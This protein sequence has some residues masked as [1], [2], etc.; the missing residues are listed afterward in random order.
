MERTCDG[1]CRPLYICD[2]KTIAYVCKGLWSVF[3]TGQAVL[4]ESF[5]KGE[6]LGLN[7]KF[8]VSQNGKSLAMLLEN[9][10]HPWDT[11]ICVSAMHIA[12]YKFSRQQ[13]QAYHRC[14]ASPK[15]DSDLAL[16]PNG[17]K[18]AVLNDRSYGLFN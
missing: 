6:R 17:S 12:V 15:T 14:C 10:H 18:L 8:S 7:V 5:K 9:I 3:V 4:I 16:P 1:L 13:G 2:D 11:G